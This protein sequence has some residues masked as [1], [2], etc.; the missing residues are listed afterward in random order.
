MARQHPDSGDAAIDNLA[1]RVR[2]LEQQF[3]QDRRLLTL[4]R[5]ATA[6]VPDPVEGQQAVRSSDDAH[7][8]YANGSWR[9]ATSNCSRAFNTTSTQS[10]DSG[11][12]FDQF[13]RYIPATCSTNDSS[14]Y[15]R[16]S[17]GGLR[18]LKSGVY[19][20]QQSVDIAANNGS[21]E[22]P[23]NLGLY[24]ELYTPAGGPSVLPT[25]T[26]LARDYR[27]FPD[28]AVTTFV[29]NNRVSLR[30]IATRD[31]VA[32]TTTSDS[33]S[34]YTALLADGATQNWQA[35]AATLIIVRLGNSLGNSSITLS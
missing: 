3:A 1:E 35:V 29:P 16:D 17:F 24:L 21:N 30:N 7:T 23:P 15:A 10:Y 28:P 5:I 11:T 18:I 20:I 6:N 2:R 25:S 4:D 19:L 26:T 33:C 22:I 12:G 8:W 9:T 34:F 32:D 14:V 27:I 13:I 31:V